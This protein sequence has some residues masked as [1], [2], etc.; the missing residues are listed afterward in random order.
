MNQQNNFLDNDKISANAPPLV[1]I[2][3]ETASGKS[4][5]AM[6]LAEQ[7]DGELV[8]ADSWTVYRGFDIGTAKPTLEDR[9]KIPHHLLDVADPAEGFSA[10]VFQRLAQEAIVDILARGKLPIMVGGTGLYIDSVLYDYSFLPPSDPALRTELNALSLDELL[11]RADELELDTSGIDLRNKRRVIRLIENNGVRPGRREMRGN[12]MLLGMAV[13][14]ENLQQRIT[15]RV[16]AMFTAG[17]EA[18]VQ[19]LAKQYSWGAEAMKGIGYREWYEYFAGAQTRDETRARIIKSSMDLAKR[20]RTWFKRNDS[21][22]WVSDRSN[23]V[24]LLT[25]FLNKSD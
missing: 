9:A 8:C 23:A 13:E 11:A 3:G 25:T 22:Q 21:I 4:A 10:A 1:A 17:L 24:D 7:F 18:E 12:T 16:D 6:D 19:A 14:R 20:Q 2:V 15:A 5:L